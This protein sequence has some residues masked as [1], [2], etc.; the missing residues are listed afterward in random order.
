MPVGRPIHVLQLIISSLF[1]FHNLTTSRTKPSTTHLG[2]PPEMVES[3]SDSSVSG[4][5]IKDI[6]DLD[7]YPLTSSSYVQQTRQELQQKSLITL[8]GFIKPDA[9]QSMIDESIVKEDEAYYSNSSHNVFFTPPDSDPDPSLPEDHYSK[10]RFSTTKGCVTTDQHPEGSFLKAL[11]SNKTFQTFLSDILGETLYEPADP[12]SGCTVHY[13]THGQMLGWHFDK[14]PFAITLMLQ[15]P[16]DGGVFEYLPQIRAL[17]PCCEGG[18]RDSVKPEFEEEV[19][20]VLKGERP[21]K[22]LDLRPGTLTVFRGDHSMHRVTKV[23]G[24]KTRI[25]SVLAYNALPGVK[26]DEERM[27]ALFG[28]TA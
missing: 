17:D 9:L 13:G 16:L 6:V 4:I 23:L 27:M 25:L 5:S 18:V 15:K 1:P 28:R 21:A 2:K 8:P 3:D 24:E 7:Q 14:S 26:L 20:Q 10:R 22:K 19:T 11:Y 12:L